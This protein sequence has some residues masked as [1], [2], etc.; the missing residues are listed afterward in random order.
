MTDEVRPGVPGDRAR[1]L[2]HCGLAAAL[3]FHLGCGGDVAS[4]GAPASDK[5]AGAGAAS[6]DGNSGGKAF[7][8]PNPDAVKPCQSPGADWCTELGSGARDVASAV[9]VDTQGNVVIT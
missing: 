7:S 6:I 2:L 9:A 5:G 3:L 1:R 8:T 4:A